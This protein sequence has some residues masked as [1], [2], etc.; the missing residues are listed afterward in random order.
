[1]IPHHVYYQLAIVRLLWLCIMLHSIWPSR[2]AALPQLHTEPVPLRFKRKRAN[3]PKPFA[4]HTGA[5]TPP[6]WGF[7]QNA[8]KIRS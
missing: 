3:A 7:I 1:M 8:C 5:L 2:D 6:I 4:L